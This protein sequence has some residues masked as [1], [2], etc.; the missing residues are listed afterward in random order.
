MSKYDFIKMGN[1]VKYDLF[2][3]GNYTVAQV[4][5]SVPKNIQDDTRVNISLRMEK[6]VKHYVTFYY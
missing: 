2:S 6:S 5:T 1:K 4:C 3:D